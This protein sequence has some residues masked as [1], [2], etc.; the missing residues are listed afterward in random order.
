MAGNLG[1]GL[2]LFGATRTDLA[3]T[4][5]RMA[6]AA[7]TGVRCTLNK[8]GGVVSRNVGQDFDVQPLITLGAVWDPRARDGISTYL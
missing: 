1:I 4:W 7:L 6:L 5:R 8:Q 3:W 2:G